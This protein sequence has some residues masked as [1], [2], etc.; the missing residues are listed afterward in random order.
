VAD[1][2]VALHRGKGLLVEDLADQAEV[3][4]NQHL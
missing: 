4:E 2:D 1:R 3:F